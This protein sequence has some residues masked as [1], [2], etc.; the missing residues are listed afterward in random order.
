M[1]GEWKFA[2]FKVYR[3]TGGPRELIGVFGAWGEADA[4]TATLPDGSGPCRVVKF[5]AGDCPWRVGELRG[6]LHTAYEL[7]RLDPAWVVRA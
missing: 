5:R 7:G 1:A 3:T 6:N 4:A 2:A